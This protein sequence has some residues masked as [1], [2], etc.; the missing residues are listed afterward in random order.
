[1][2]ADFLAPGTPEGAPVRSQNNR[3]LRPEQA[4]AVNSSSCLL[5]PIQPFRKEAR[6]VR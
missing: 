2:P 4:L 5:V 3:P 1:M 6:E